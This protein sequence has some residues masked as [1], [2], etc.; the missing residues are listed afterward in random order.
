[1]EDRFFI[2]RRPTKDSTNNVVVSTGKLRQASCLSGFA[3]LV[4]GSSDRP[5]VGR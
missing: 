5:S 4:E 3:V 2:G 1:M